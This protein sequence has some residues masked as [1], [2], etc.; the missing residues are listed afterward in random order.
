MAHYRVLVVGSIDD[1][2]NIY[3]TL[4]DSSSESAA[5]LAFGFDYLDIDNSDT[6]VSS[7]PFT[8]ENEDLYKQVLNGL[9]YYC[10]DARRIDAY[11]DYGYVN[12]KDQME[13]EY[14]RGVSME[15][16]R[17]RHERNKAKIIEHIKT[18]PNNQVFIFCD[19][20]L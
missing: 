18:L 2:Q 3:D 7:E 4:P 8:K 14:E 11:G 5:E 20:H 16:E 17:N 15:E 12:I 10:I 13:E 19:S 1:I 6:I 9:F